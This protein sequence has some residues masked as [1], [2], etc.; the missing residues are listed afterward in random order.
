M[1]TIKIRL[2]PSSV[3]NAIKELDGYSDEIERKC[4]ELARRLAEFGLQI[5]SADY[6]ACA[7]QGNKDVSVDIEDIPNGYR[8]IASGQ[9]VL[10]LEFGAGITFSSVQHPLNAEFGMGPGTYPGVG[11][12]DDPKGW[13]IPKDYGGGHTYGNPPAMAMYNAAQE[14]RRN[15]Q[16]IAEEVFA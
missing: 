16:H 3:G 7:Y 11:H 5:A 15:V 13:W 8:V 14:I 9:A 2:N 10:F 6:S 1:K 4:D 12:W